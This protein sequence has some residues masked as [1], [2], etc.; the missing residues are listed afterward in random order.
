MMNDIKIGLEVHCQLTNLKTKLFCSCSS[1]YRN[2]PPNSN[3]CVICLGHPGTL[4]KPN[5]KAIEFAI[6]AGLALKSKINER[7]LFSRKNYFYVDMNKNFQISMYETKNSPPICSGGYL[8]ISYEGRIK[9]IRIR[10]IQLEEDPARLVH[11]GPIDVSPC[12]LVDYNRAGIALL[13]VVTEPDISTP[14]E[15]RIFLQKLRSVFEHI[16]IF[17]GS[18]E[19]AMRCDANI[20]IKGEARVEIKNISSFKEVERALNYEIL[21][22][23]NL[24]NKGEKVLRETRHWDEIRKVTIS[25]R[26]KEEEYDYR[27][28]P[29]PDIPPIHITQELIESIKLKMPELPDERAERFTKV[30]GIPQYDANI[31]VSQK[32]L[33]DFFEECVKLFNEPK[34]ISNWIISD[35]LGVLNNRGL[36]IQ[37]SKITPIAMVEMLKMIKDGII[38]GKIGKIILPE[39]VETGKMPSQIVKE[40]NMIRISDEDLIRKIVEEV[41]REN[42]KAVKD[43][44][45]NENAINFLIGQVMKKTRGRGDPKLVN[46]II[47]SKIKELK[48]REI[49]DK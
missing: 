36:E 39:I 27:Y 14:K 8:D 25:L 31:L 5:K 38:S 34:T 6:M 42:E 15:A 29:E 30:Y 3:V 20:S 4:P 49:N 10:R 40:K 7:V 13:E 17:D 16:G 32:A 1:D 46:E 9:R 41:F 45:V 37:E 18:L 2:K 35:L 21:R 26:E 22:Q 44:L 24:I 43:A 47:R 12:T 11:I 28:F 23:M 48:S 33:A 19:G